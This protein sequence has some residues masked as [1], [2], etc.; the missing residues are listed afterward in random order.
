VTSAAALRALLAAAAALGGCA[1][2]VTV[3]VAEPHTRVVFNGRD[4]GTVPPEGEKVEVPP[5]LAAIPYAI[6]DGEARIDGA[7]PRS[8]P[9]WWM[10]GAGAAGAACCAPSLAAAGFCL[11]NPAVL[12]A[13]LGFLA[14]GDAGVLTASFVSPSWLTLPAMTLCGAAG[15]TPL[16]LALA[17]EALPDEVVLRAP[18]AAAAEAPVGRADGGAVGEAVGQA[19]AMGF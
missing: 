12:V 3:R 5:G 7:V 18:Q 14:A 4:V 6:E 19:P 16:G 10:V 8:E 2:T 11:A 17:A 15:M 13:P 9:V 1:R